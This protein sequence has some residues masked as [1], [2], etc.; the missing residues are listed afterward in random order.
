MIRYSNRVS[1]P[2]RHESLIRHDDDAVKKYSRV[3]KST[4]VW[5]ILVR[6]HRSKRPHLLIL[7]ISRQKEEGITWSAN[8]NTDVIHREKEPGNGPQAPSK[9]TVS[10]FSNKALTEKH[11][12]HLKH[13]AEC[14]PGTSSRRQ[15]R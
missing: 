14:V 1:K 11:L 4:H 8:E 15:K 9:L 3:I 10:L 13:K 6:R 12:K 7:S 5:R 2:L